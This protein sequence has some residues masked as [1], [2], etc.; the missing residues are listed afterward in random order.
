MLAQTCNLIR[1]FP[2]SKKARRCDPAGRSL[3]KAA[4]VRR[5]CH[6]P[7]SL[8]H[9]PQAIKKPATSEAAGG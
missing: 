1:L 7:L 5:P 6:E 2:H 9:V 8:T 4:G 3:G